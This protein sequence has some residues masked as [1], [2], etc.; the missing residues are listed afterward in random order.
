MICDKMDEFIGFAAVIPVR[1]FQ[2]SPQWVVFVEV[3]SPNNRLSWR[4]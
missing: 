4:V 1:V 3:T 2:S